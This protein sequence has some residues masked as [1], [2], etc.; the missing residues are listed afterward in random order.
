MLEGIMEVEL[1]P[2]PKALMEGS[3]SGA[4]MNMSSNFSALS[5]FAASAPAPSPSSSVQTGFR[6]YLQI[7]I[8]RG[9][10]HLNY[11]YPTQAEAHST[12]LGQPKV[13][14]LLQICI[15]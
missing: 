10:L 13:L 3:V 9:H 5:I 2:A 4:S 15:S 8:L 7:E 14:F 1:P 12:L 11:G 6:L